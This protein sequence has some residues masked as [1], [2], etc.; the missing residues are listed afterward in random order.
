MTHKT[1]MLTKVVLTLMMLGLFAAILCGCTTVK[2][3]VNQHIIVDSS[4]IIEH[5]PKQLK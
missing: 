2:I 3:A 1:T 4:G 5:L